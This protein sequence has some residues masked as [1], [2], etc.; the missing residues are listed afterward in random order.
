MT[1]IDDMAISCRQ[2]CIC[3]PGTARKCTQRRQVPMRLTLLRIIA[4]ICYNLTGVE[5]KG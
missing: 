2:N 4:A 3:P 5:N 1:P